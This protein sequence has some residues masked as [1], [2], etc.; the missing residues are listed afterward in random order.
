[1]DRLWAGL[2]CLI[3]YHGI[4]IMH[5]IIRSIVIQYNVDT[6]MYY[7]MFL[8]F[9]WVVYSISHCMSLWIKACEKSEM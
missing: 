6:L 9:Y 8:S 5:V 3:M 7:N 2:L 4:L 1:M